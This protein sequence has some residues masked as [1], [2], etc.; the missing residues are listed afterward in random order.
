MY[1]S[2][3][4]P[5]LAT[6][7]VLAAPLPA[8]DLSGIDRTIAKEPAYK[9]KPKYCL[10]VFGLEAK[11]RVWLVCD[12]N[13]LYV[14][15]NGNGDLTESGKR[16]DSAKGNFHVGDITE[17]DG[18]TKHTRL[19]V[20][21]FSDPDSAMLSISVGG[22]RKYYVDSVLVGNRPQDAPIV[23]FNGPLTL[24]PL[25]SFFRVERGTKPSRLYFALGTAGLGKGTFAYTTSYKPDIPEKAR[26]L[27][28]IAFPNKAPGAPPI[29]VTVD[30]VP[31]K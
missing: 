10:L 12:G 29:I 18:K 28:E 4:L 9:N 16:V 20:Q 23:H 1:P 22:N 25:N 17:A 7:V 3:L 15:R 14:D 24:G 8:A 21:F 26:P 6:L 5:A 13:I 19:T 11:T 2:H 27:A 31:D 30:L